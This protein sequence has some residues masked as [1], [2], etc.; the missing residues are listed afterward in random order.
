MINEVS[1]NDRD[2]VSKAM[3]SN[4]KFALNMF[5]YGGSEIIIIDI[6]KK[7]RYIKVSVAALNHGDLRFRF[8]NKASYKTFKKILESEY[9][10]LNIVYTNGVKAIYSGY[11]IIEAS[12]LDTDLRRVLGIV[13]KDD[14]AD[15]DI[16][17]K[18][19]CESNYDDYIMLLSKYLNENA[20]FTESLNKRLEAASDSDKLLAMVNNN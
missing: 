14:I 7:K 20:R 16:E 15:N 1:D 10:G 6:V 13:Y 18:K 19:F 9:P 17:W 2:L 12:G 11:L 3:V 5:L 8:H 4:N